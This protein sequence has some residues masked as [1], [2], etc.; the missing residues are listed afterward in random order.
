VFLILAGAIRKLVIAF[1]V[2]SGTPTPSLGAFL[3]LNARGFQNNVYAQ[4]GLIMLIGLAAK[5]RD[6][7][8]RI[9]ED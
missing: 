6:P 9:C 2:C 3:A 7:H 5:K 4:I 8:R 1:S